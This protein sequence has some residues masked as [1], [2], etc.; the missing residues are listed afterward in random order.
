MTSTR[1]VLAGAGG[2]H[3]GAAH[4]LI[5]VARID[6]E[7]DRDFDRLVELGERRLLDDLERLLGLVAPAE[8]AVLRGG[9]VLLAV[10]LHQS[11]T[12]T[13]I[14][15]AAP[16]TIAIADSIESQFRS[17]ILISAIF[18][19]CALVILP[20]LV[21]IRLTRSLLEAELPSSAGSPR[22]AS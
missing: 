15:R 22:A 12:S 13:P 10:G 9:L 16:A 1:T 4:D 17:G 7:A 11:T 14:E 6:A 19:T 2:E 3:D 20:D 5:G 8:L 21:A 18:L